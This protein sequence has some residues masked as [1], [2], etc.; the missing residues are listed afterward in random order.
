M[1][2]NVSAMEK[3]ETL[4]TDQIRVKRR[5]GPPPRDYSA[6]TTPNAIISEHPSINTARTTAHRIASRHTRTFVARTLTDG[7]HVVIA[8]P[9]GI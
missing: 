6:V 4:T 8:N 3:P 9:D 5:P 2:R 7:R 1:M